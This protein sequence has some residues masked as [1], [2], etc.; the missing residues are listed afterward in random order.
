MV[1]LEEKG[2]VLNIARRRQAQ[3]WPSTFCPAGRSTP[4]N[5]ASVAGAQEA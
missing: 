5:F 2:G 1:L 3:S 4:S